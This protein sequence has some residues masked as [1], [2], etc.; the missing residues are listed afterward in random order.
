MYFNTLHV[1]SSILKMQQFI[2]FTTTVNDYKTNHLAIEVQVSY[3]YIEL[4]K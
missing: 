4:N 1:D 3:I 2:E